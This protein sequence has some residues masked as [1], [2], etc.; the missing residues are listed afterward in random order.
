MR[1]RH[2]QNV[3]E[4]TVTLEVRSLA[5]TLG[6]LA[7]TLATGE[8]SA[9]RIA[10]ATPALLFKLLTQKRWELLAA[11][12]GSGPVSVRAA[13]RLVG[14]DVKSVHGDVQTLIKAGILEKTAAGRIVFPYS[15][16][17]VDFTLKAA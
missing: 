9:P 2:E 10:F 16:I 1:T 7:Q 11:M 17:H 4:R 12:T 3:S 8:A 5:A 6:D 15:A 14:R 13:A